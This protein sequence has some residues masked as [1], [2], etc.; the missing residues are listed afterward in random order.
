ADAEYH[1]LAKAKPRDADLF[2]DWGYSYYQRT[3]WKEAEKQL[4]KALELDP[5]H[6]RACC[7]LGL[8]LG[9]EGRYDEAL[10]QFRTVVGEA[11]AHC[12]LACVYWTQGK[13]EEARRECYQANQ[14]TPSCTKSVDILA[15]LDQIGK[16][17]E[18][19]EKL[20]AA[21]PRRG[22][23]RQRPSRE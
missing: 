9:Q 5:R 16:P 4:R 22:G 23:E 6:A 10:Q 18:A 17:Q 15:A 8:V 3:Q 7:N 13:I 14:L 2:N 20:A 11:E 19:T 1:K 21:P 12:N